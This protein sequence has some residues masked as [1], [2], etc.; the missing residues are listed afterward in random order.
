[1][2]N[3]AIPKETLERIKHI[4]LTLLALLFMA[5][6][7]K[8]EDEFTTHECYFSFNC[9]YHNASQLINAVNSYETFAIVTTKPLSGKAYTVVTSIYGAADSEDHITNE[10]ETQR[11]HILGLSNGLVIG[12]SSM[13]QTLYA[14]DRQCPNCYAVSGITAAPLS[15]ADNGNTLKCPKCSRK[16][17]VSGGGIISE[18]E[19]GQKLL[20]YRIT[21]DGTYIYVQNR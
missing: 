3:T 8:A 4:T 9:T 2:L 10:M 7:Q 21:Y 1:M 6:C 5:S 12:R 14:F 13:D 11:A 17:N 16:Y 20:R 15:W 19:Q 18:G